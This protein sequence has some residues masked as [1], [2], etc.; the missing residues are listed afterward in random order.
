VPASRTLALLLAAA[1]L[2]TGCGGSGGNSAA[3]F[4]GVK[5][6]VATTVDD[7]ESAAKKSDEAKICTDLLTPALI[8]QLRAADKSSCN[9]AIHDAIKDADTFDMTVKTVNVTGDNATAVVDSKHGSSNDTFTLEKVGGRWKI[10]SFG[11]S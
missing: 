2:A 7:L 3:D 6:D 4:S 5:Q 11:G 1:G 10:S 8:A 9:T